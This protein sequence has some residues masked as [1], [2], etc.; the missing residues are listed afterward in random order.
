MPF[1]ITVLPIMAVEDAVSTGRYDAVLA[2]MPETETNDAFPW[3]NVGCVPRTVVAVSDL[4]SR[5][6]L[7]AEQ[8]EAYL[9]KGGI[10]PDMVHVQ[11]IIDFGLRAEDEGWRSVLVHCHAAV[12]RSPAAALILAAM[13]DG[14]GHESESANRVAKL[15]PFCDF[16]PIAHSNTDI[17]N[18]L[19]EV[20][21]LRFELLAANHALAAAIEV[22]PEQTVRTHIGA[23]FTWRDQHAE[24]IRR[25]VEIT[26]PDE[27][28]T[29]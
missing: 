24:A 20:D 7:T 3:P 6:Q 22:I 21:R 11:A 8:T 25:A 23:A 26:S 10:P 16:A 19:D 9:A 12:S 2:V 13:Q 15:S 5:R 1:R 29:P 28:P 17:G 27:T 18:L 4:G 14:P